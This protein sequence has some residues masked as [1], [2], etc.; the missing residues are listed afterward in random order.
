MGKL[1]FLNEA[2]FFDEDCVRFIGVD[3]EKNVVCGV[4][5]YALKHCDPSLP[6]HG[7]LPA[8]AF[9]AAFEKLSADVHDAAR[10][11]YKNGKFET[12]RA[13]PNC[14]NSFPGFLSEV[15]AFG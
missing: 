3:G 12:E 5:T 15:S 1:S 13:D 8:E 6:H 9:I 11:K 14:L 2:P 4:T 10:T 7:L